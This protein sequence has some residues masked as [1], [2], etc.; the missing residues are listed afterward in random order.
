MKERIQIEAVCC[1][2]TS[3]PSLSSLFSLLFLLLFRLVRAG[4]RHH[5]LQVV[6]Q[7]RVVDGSVARARAKRAREGTARQ[8]KREGGGNCWNGREERDKSLISSPS[9]FFFPFPPFLFF[10]F[11]LFPLLVQTSSWSMLPPATPPL[12]PSS[13]WA[14]RPT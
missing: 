11:F 7:P 5:R 13:F 14:T 6:R 8:G 4:A 3:S 9:L 12:S 1:V 10:F 2:L